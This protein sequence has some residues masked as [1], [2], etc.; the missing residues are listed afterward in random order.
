MPLLHEKKKFPQLIWKSEIAK[1]LAI[2]KSKGNI[3]TTHFILVA[4]S[5]RQSVQVT[6]GHLFTIMGQTGTAPLGMN[7]LMEEEAGRKKHVVV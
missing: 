1:R 6:A 7:L 4:S 5:L 2:L 3:G